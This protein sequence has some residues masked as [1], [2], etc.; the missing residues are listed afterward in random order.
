LTLW[1]VR[2]GRE[3]EQE[4]GVLQNNIVAIGWNE[5]PDLSSV[6]SLSSLKR[7]YTKAYPQQ[8]IK[9]VTTNVAQIWSFIKRI[10]K[11]D[12]IALPLKSQPQIA[13]GEI[14]D[15]Y[16]YKEYN[17]NIKHT[18]QI[19]WLGNIPRSDLDD[20]IIKSLGTYMTVGRIRKNTAEGQIRRILQDRGVTSF[21]S[22]TQTDDH[23]NTELVE[24]L[25]III[26]D[27]RKWVNSE[28]GQTS[29]HCTKRKARS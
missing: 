5:L 8:N 21:S 9:T 12:L 15:D 17:G 7:I 13:I 3:G 10:K 20:D 11:G 4:K 16:E 24:N 1:L 29:K 2:A 23:E 6:D 25:Q 28:A 19:K 27:F 18:R 26:N 14:Q 22:L